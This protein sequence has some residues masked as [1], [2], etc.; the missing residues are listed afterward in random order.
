MKKRGVG[1]LEIPAYDFPVPRHSA[2][3]LWVV[4]LSPD[5]PRHAFR[6]PAAIPSFTLF[7]PPGVPCPPMSTHSNTQSSL[8]SKFKYYLSCAVP[9]GHWIDAGEHS[10]TYVTV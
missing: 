9:G 8:R 5:P 7:L 3:G 2:L 4:S 6:V 1:S 10:V